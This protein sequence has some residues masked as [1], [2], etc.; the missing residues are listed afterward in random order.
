MFGVLFEDHS[1]FIDH[2]LTVSTL[3]PENPKEERLI[4]F[5]ENIATETRPDNLWDFTHARAKP[6]RAEKEM[7]IC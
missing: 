5:A 4:T 6:F 3:D 2:Q 7:S 1:W